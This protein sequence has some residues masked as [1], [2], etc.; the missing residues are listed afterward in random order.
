MQAE[1]DERLKKIRNTLAQRGREWVVAAVVEGSLGYHTPTD[2]DLLI[3][4]LIER[5][6]TQDWCE[7]CLACYGGDL[8]SMIHSDIVT[9]ERLEK[10]NPDRARRVVD[11]VKKVKELDSVQQQTLGLLYPTS[12]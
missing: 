7:R 4:D 10:M 3:S 5:G 11:Y 8:V 1:R 12:V 2:A 6:R 9:F